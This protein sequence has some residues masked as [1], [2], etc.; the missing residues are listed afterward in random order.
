[1]NSVW[2]CS[3]VHE[4]CHD[5]KVTPKIRRPMALCSV[6]RK[7]AVASPLQRRKSKSDCLD[8]PLCRRA[9]EVSRRPYLD[10]R[11]P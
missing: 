3:H 7:L 9:I 10:E 5:V 2:P 6:C 4:Y 11:F 8:Y 1:M